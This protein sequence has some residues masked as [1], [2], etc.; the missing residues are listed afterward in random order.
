MHA[1]GARSLFLQR[2]DATQLLG[3]QS[4]PCHTM[5]CMACVVRA[6]QSNGWKVM[7]TINLSIIFFIFGITLETKELKEAFKGWKTLLLGILSILFIT[8]LTGFIFINMDFSVGLDGV[9][10]DAASA[11]QWRQLASMMCVH[12][13]ARAPQPGSLNGLAG[14]VGQVRMK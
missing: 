5:L 12:S 10:V 4:W 2:P 1:R 3:T 7:S 8:G 11:A 13:T 14:R 6:A 9:P